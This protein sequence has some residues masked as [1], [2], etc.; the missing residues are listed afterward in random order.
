[1]A[2]RVGVLKRLRESARREHQMKKESR[3][4]QRQRENAERRASVPPGVDP[5]IAGIVPG[6]QPTGEE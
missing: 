3:R 2:G 4:E 6:P 5:D 1:M